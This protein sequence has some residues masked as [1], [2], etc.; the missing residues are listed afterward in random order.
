MARP[1]IIVGASARAAAFSARDAGFEPWCADLF[2]DV[3]LQSIA[4]VQRIVGYPHALPALLAASPDAPWMYTGALENY[5][6]LVDELALIRPLVGNAGRAL[7]AAR[8]PVRIARELAEAGFNSPRVSLS[9]VEL[10]RDGSWLRKPLRSA[11][12]QGVEVWTGAHTGRASDGDPYY[13]QQRI[14][15]VPISAV[16]VA[17]DGAAPILGVTRQLVGDG[18]SGACNATA[19]A[20]RARQASYRY[21]GSIGPQILPESHYQALARAGQV[22][23]RR[24]GLSGLF[25][26]DAIWNEVGVWPVEINPRYTAS[27]EVLERA[28]ALRTQIRRSR[29]MLSIGLHDAACTLRQLPASLG[30]SDESFAG[31]LIYYAPCEGCFSSDAARWATQQNLLQSWPVVADIPAAGSGFRQG[32][33]VVTLRAEGAS[34]DQVDSQLRQISTEF[35]A[36]L[37]RR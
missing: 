34:L 19:V 23:A 2:A 22:V 12:G 20:G 17:A 35:E 15:G 11:G 5:P 24:C 32:E 6:D 1:L 3:D 29:R 4:T 10:P 13:Y 16:F 8:D 28:S 18:G 37:L 36:H 33:P 31:K 27:I 30:Q 26:M 25:G 14:D 7:R 9:A 21:C